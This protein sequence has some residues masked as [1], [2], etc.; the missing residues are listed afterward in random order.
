MAYQGIE[1]SEGHHNDIIV[2]S[3]RTKIPLGIK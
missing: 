2:Y 3:K 1:I